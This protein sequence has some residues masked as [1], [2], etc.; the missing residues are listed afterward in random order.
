MRVHPP[1]F[2][3]EAPSAKGA[4]PA[5]PIAYSRPT[6]HQVRDWL[7]REIAKHAPPPS[8]DEIRRDLWLPVKVVPI[9]K[10]GGV[11]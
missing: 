9:V 10:N 8:I 7:R 5:D 11:K 2:P 1:L 6:K 3:N 4:P